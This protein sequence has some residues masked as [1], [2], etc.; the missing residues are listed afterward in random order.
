MFSKVQYIS[1]GLTAPEQL[2]N[3]RAALDAGIT[4]VQ[5]RYKHVGQDAVRA[6]A[7]TVKPYCEQYNAMFIINDWVPVAQAV[8]ADGVHL[9]LTDSPV[10]H[11]RDVLGYSRVIGGTA[12]TLEDINQRVAEGCDYIGVG[13]FRFTS[14]KEK[15]SPVVGLA[16][17]KRLIGGLHADAHLVPL[18]AIGGIT[19]DDADAL[20]R[21]GLYGICL[22]GGI[23]GAFDKRET[24]RLLHER[25]YG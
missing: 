19:V 18:Y 1:Q 16:G 21:A 22:S 4:W 17:Y 2:A 23:T 13:P 6:L 15:L 25:M 11:A 3:I 24:V 12:N 5:L 9:G 14:T 20:R 10:K 7:E 8:D